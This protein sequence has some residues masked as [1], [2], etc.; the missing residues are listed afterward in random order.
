MGWVE[1][2]HPFHPLRGRRFRILKTRRVSGVETLIVE[3][4]PLG[5]C[6]VAREWTDMAHPN[7]HDG[8]TPS[9][10]RFDCLVAL[11][12]LIEA[13]DRAKKKG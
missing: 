12:E 4:T 2:T 11:A 6:A 1:I 7:A 5:T 8:P 13:V 3:G 10:L 9:F